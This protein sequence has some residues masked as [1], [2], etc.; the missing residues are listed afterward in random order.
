M[1]E[2]LKGLG[3]TDELIDTIMAEHGK[4]MTRSTETINQLKDQVRDLKDAAKPFEG[5]DL[6]ALN[7]QITT[8]TADKEN[9][10]S[11]HK[12]AI[13]ALKKDYAIKAAVAK[14]NPLDEI[15][16]MAHLDRDKIVFNEETG[17]LTGFKEQDDA[18]HKDYAYMFNAASGGDEHRG[19]DS[20]SAK[21]MSLSD[22][23]AEHY[24]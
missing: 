13:T 8:L 17:E 5:V 21:S 3:L 6:D 1:R 22:A 23:V 19:I 24:K 18:I 20:D 16:Y 15:A 7:N 9:A 12:K 4:L 10:E 11:E 14:S 2:F